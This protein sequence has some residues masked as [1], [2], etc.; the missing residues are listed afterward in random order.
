MFQLFKRK[1]Q[2]KEKDPPLTDWSY[3]GTDMHSHFIPGIDDGAATLADSIHLVRSMQQMGFTRLVTTPHISLDFYPNSHD[4]IL[5]GLE[6]VRS[7]MLKEGLHIEL[8]AAAEYMIDPAFIEKLN[9]GAPLLTIGKNY[10]LFEMGF[11]QEDPYLYQVIFR[12]QSMGYK[13]ILA[14]PERYSYYHQ[15]PLSFF[16]DLKEKGCLLQLNTIALS[17][18]Y[19][20]PVKLMAEK[21]LQAN[22]YDFLGSDMHHERHLKSLKSILYADYAL[23]LQKFTFLNQS[24][25]DLRIV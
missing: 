9:A 8:Y 25:F 16:T 6:K 22:L 17:G 23:A 20:K 5:H 10:I 24:L 19:G 14:H 3:I 2:L 18:Y 11:V 13:P 12:L 21:L 4:D 15:Q 7:E 1:T